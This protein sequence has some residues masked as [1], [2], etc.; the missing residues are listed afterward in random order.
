MGD[1][2]LYAE[3]IIDKD[4]YIIHYYIREV[5][6]DALDIHD[7]I[8]SPNIDVGIPYKINFD[9]YEEVTK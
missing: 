7:K 2:Y 5:F 3:L 4:V 8:K 1:G 6:V 9:I